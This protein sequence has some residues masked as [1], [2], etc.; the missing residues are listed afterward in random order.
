MMV[1]QQPSQNS[2]NHLLSV[3]TT[4]VFCISRIILLA[5]SE[6]SITLLASFLMVLSLPVVPISLMGGIQFL[7]LGFVVVSRSTVDCNL[8]SFLFPTQWH[9]SP[10]DKPYQTLLF[11]VSFS[12][13]L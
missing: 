2:V 12:I 13:L 6:S 9:C 10:V 1:S 11:L 5:I 8:C 3:N 4:T 7:V